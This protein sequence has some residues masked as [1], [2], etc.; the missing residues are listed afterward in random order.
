MNSLAIELSTKQGSVAV[1]SD[2]RLVAEKTWKEEGTRSQHVFHVIP[3]LLEEASVAPDQ[4]GTYYVGRGPGSYS[5]L[6]IAMTAARGMALPSEAKVFALS[7]GEAL[8]AET[9]EREGATTVAVVG[10]A[11]RNM[12][13]VGVF[14]VLAMQLE[15]LHSWNV[16]DR[17]SLPA[18]LPGPCVVVSSDWKRI[19]DH[20]EAMNLPEGR[21][22]RES[23]YPSARYVGKVG[24]RKLGSGEPSEPLSPIYSHPPV[25][26]K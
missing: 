5:G 15:T 21:L 6:R 11:R 19:G 17:A 7:S 9:A 24:M 2:E 14:R 16:M 1:F 4:L 18:V 20:L 23:R 13:W 10:D 12:I 26:R 8:A 22:I 3:N 25:G